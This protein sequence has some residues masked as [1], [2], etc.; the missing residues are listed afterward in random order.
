[1]LISNNFERLRHFVEAMNSSNSTNHKVKVLEEYTQDI[2]IAGVL[3]YT[4]TPYK[5]Y[6][7][8]SKNLEKRSDLLADPFTPRISFL[9]LLDLLAD[10]VL[11]GHA[12]IGAV[13]RFV[14]DNV[15]YKDLIYQVIDRNL[16]TRATTTLINRVIPNLIP[17]FD[18]ALAHDITKVKGVDPID[19]TWYC[20][21]KL[22]GI[23]CITIIRD[24]KI[25]FFSRNGKEFETLSVVLDQIEELGLTDCV[26]DGEICL[27]KEDGSDD[28]QGIL[29]EIQ[30]KNHTIR[31]PRY[32]IFDVLTLEEFDSKSGESPLNERL[33]RLD[34]NSRKNKTLA[35]LPQYLIETKE[36]LEKFKELS[37]KSGWEGLILRRNVGYE[38]KRSK[39]MLKVKEF[40]DAEY[41]VESVI[42]EEQ[43]IIDSG[44]EK[45]EEVLSAVI[46]KHKGDPVRVG[47]GFTLSERRKYHKSPD[48]ILGKMI[49]VQYFEETIDQDGKNSLRFPVFKINHGESRSI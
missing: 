17:T 27:M 18:V 44:H 28:F 9:E 19:G 48:L 38:G 39:N 36:D 42:M 20:S 47:S 21:R 16:E 29:K 41:L 6:G 25:K 8:T 11:T 30:R 7:V 46:V 34:I 45:V 2:F 22:D 43:R 32:W 1:M 37:A 24:G 4:Y 23:R 13:N 12:A 26:L 35:I 33:C 3:H 15:E 49:T 10:R 31:N 5:Q 40:F 14:Q